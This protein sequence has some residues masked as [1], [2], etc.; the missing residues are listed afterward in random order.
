[1]ARPEVDIRTTATSNTQHLH[2][3]QEEGQDGS[4]RIRFDDG[5][6]Q[7]HVD[8]VCDTLDDEI[9][10]LSSSQPWG[11]AHTVSRG[12]GATG[13]STATRMLEHMPRD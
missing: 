8:D 13:R 4:Q 2:I 10:D 9:V 3:Q 5:G 7:H 11:A 6:T 1:M 12:D